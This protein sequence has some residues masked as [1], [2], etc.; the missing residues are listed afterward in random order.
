MPFRSHSHI[1]AALDTFVCNSRRQNPSIR[2]A[3]GNAY[4]WRKF[5]FPFR[6]GVPSSCARCL[7]SDLVID[8]DTAIASESDTF[9]GGN[10]EIAIGKSSSR[11]GDVAGFVVVGDSDI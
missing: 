3:H 6:I 10:A 5:F 4:C 9:R 1:L 7:S 8:V 2:P 11:P